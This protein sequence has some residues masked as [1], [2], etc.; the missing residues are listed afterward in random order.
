[1]EGLSPSET[2]Q[3]RSHAPMPGS[4]KWGH[5]PGTPT[6]LSGLARGRRLSSAH[7][8]RRLSPLGSLLRS[9]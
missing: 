4:V 7:P 8:H 9:D 3:E 1:M 6:P 5:A 2:T